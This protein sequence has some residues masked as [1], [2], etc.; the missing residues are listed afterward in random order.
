MA[1]IQFCRFRPKGGILRSPARNSRRMWYVGM[2]PKTLI[3][4]LADC[5]RTRTKKN[6]KH[7]RTSAGVQCPA[8]RY[9]SIFLG[10][11]S[12]TNSSRSFTRLT[13]LLIPV[14]LEFTILTQK[15]ESNATIEFLHC[16][17]HTANQPQNTIGHDNQ[18][19]KHINGVI[20]F[21]RKL[22]QIRK[23]KA[24]RLESCAQEHSGC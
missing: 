12:V 21:D 18:I 17:V 13:V 24:Y 16:T 22:N 6:P 15:M 14:S 23:H 5:L 9:T 19:V 20:I 11:E 1:R 2:H 4:E 7:L 3:I 8:L 10:T